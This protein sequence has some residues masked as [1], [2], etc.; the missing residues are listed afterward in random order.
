MVAHGDHL[1]AVF[2]DANVYS[3]DP[4]WVHL[5]HHMAYRPPIRRAW[6]GGRRVRRRRS[7][8]GARLPLYGNLPGVGRLRARACTGVCNFGGVCHPGDTGPRN[9]A[10]ARRPCRGRPAGASA[11]GTGL[12]L[13]RLK[14]DPNHNSLV[15][16]QILVRTRA[17]QRDAH[18][19]EAV[20]L[21]QL[22]QEALHTFAAGDAHA[23]DGPAR[24]IGETHGAAGFGD[25]AGRGAAGIGCRHDGPGAHACDAMNRNTVLLEHLPSVLFGGHASCA[26]LSG[27]CRYL[28]G[29]SRWALF[30]R[31]HAGGI[32][33]CQDDAA[34]LPPVPVQRGAV[35]AERARLQPGEPVAAAGAAEED[36]ELVADEFAAAVG[37][38]RRAVSEACPVLL[39]AVGGEPPDAAAVWHSRWASRELNSWLRPSSVDL[40]RSE[41]HTSE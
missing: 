21:E 31:I 16:T 30:G 5:P 32:A 40:R 37:E 41:E 25:L 34:E 13:H 9:D 19:F 12:I 35:M 4:V 7:W 2:P 14:R 11:V 10:A 33:R 39:A 17:A 8:A 22:A 38:D 6:S 29:R 24:H 20:A 27:K 15:W 36:R 3:H 26:C 23:C 28:E 1:G 18:L